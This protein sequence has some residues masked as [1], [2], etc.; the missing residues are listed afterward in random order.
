VEFQDFPLKDEIKEAL[1]RRG[2][3]A[4]TPI[5]A[6][7]LPLALEGRDLIGQARTGTGKTLAFALPIAQRLEAS[8]QRGRKPRALVLTP[9][10]ELALQVAS[11]M[12]AVAPHLKVVPVYG[13]TG[14]GKQKEELQRG[15]D[16]V[17]ATPGRALDY[18]RQ[19]VLD[20]SEVEIA[21]LDEADEML[22]MGFEEEVEA[23]LAATPPSRQTLLFSAT[24]PTWA[25]RLAER[26]MKSPV[27][28]NVVKEEG[29]TYQEEAILAPT[30]RLALLSDLLYVKAPKRA[31]VFTKTKAET[32]EVATGLLRLGHAARAIHGDLSQADRERVMRAFREGEVKVLVATDV[33]ARGW[34]SPR[35]TWW[36]TTGFPTSPRPTSTAPGARGGRAG[37]GRW[38]SSTAPGRS[39]N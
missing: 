24:L 20:L 35:W 28:I 4:P 8:R 7:A 25:R 9:T 15:A 1:Y 17:V 31:I 32:E 3:T 10:R 23:I 19:G 26:Y 6:A 12:A 21:V 37:A 2:I 18:L 33:A 14:Y 11:E 22:S 27:V 13:G 16:V 34:T 36:S 30:D 5:Q 38:S 39:G 29:V